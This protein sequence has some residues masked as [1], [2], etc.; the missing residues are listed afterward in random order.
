MLFGNFVESQSKDFSE[1]IDDDESTEDYGYLSDSDLEDGEDDKAPFP[2]P[3]SKSKIH[4]LDLSG[5]DKV[6]CEGHEER[7]ERG[8]VVEIPDMAFV[9]SVEVDNA[10]IV[11]LITL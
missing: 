11:S 1:A 5:E 3:T 2:N 4:P 8:K 9:T 6:V 10:F 7:V